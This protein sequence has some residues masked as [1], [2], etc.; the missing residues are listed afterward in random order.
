MIDL[1]LHT[2]ASDGAYSPEELLLRASSV[3]VRTLSITDHD[4]M[5]AVPKASALADSFGVELLA[6]IEI[7][8]VC[9][10]HDIHILGY[11]LTVHPTGLD[12]FL[13]AQR[14]HRT[15]RLRE[16]ANRL[17]DLG[18]GVDID[19]L[20]AERAAAGRS[21]G[22]PHLAQALVAARHATSV[23]EAFERWLGDGRAAWVPRHGPSPEQVI[24]TI[25][26][27]GGVASLA[28]P[29]LTGNRRLV[30]RLAE[31]GL[32]AVEV[33]HSQHDPVTKKRLLK[34]ARSLGL[35]VTGGSDFHSDA[36]H[37]SSHLGRV[38]LPVMEFQAFRDRLTRADHRIE[39]AQSDSE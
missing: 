6:G 33:Y 8:A 17:T 1:H 27:A 12:T 13:I 3:G 15:D 39:P 24:E 9:D 34:Q 4:T 37:R 31:V 20:L 18:V 28:H 7:T 10:G 19:R 25:S 22:R 21:P 23:R 32:E 14:R 30:S 26:Q 11:F 29:G 5:A 38:G 16:M 2:T 36:D 35:A